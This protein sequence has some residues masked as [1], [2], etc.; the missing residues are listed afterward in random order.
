[1]GADVTEASA[2]LYRRLAVV[3]GAAYRGLASVRLSLERAQ[4]RCARGLV[5]QPRS[6][7][8]F[9]VA[10]PKAGT[11]VL[12]MMLYQLLSDGDPEFRHIDC[13][14]PWFDIHL[15]RDVLPE[16]RTS[17]RVF[18]THL[19]LTELPSGGRY[20]Y[21][22]RDPKDSCVS[23][24]HQFTAE[25]GRRVPLERFVH[26]FLAGDVPWG[27][28]VDHVRSCA[29]FKHPDRVL[30]VQYADLVTN[31]S[32]VVDRVAHFIG[33]KLTQAKRAETLER[34][35]FAYMKTRNVKF[36][37]RWAAGPPDS[38][39]FIRNGRNGG[40]VDELTPAMART[41]DEWAECGLENLAPSVAS[42]SRVRQRA[43][44]EPEHTNAW[45]RAVD[46]RRQ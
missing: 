13:V 38:A 10:Y 5:H 24:Y 9:I 3:F 6:D 33:V 36:D 26:Q 42:M 19:P 43:D 45:R 46:A 7:D 18:K 22:L 8:I 27:S 15:T 44:D 29:R 25:A 35:S 23:Y 37:P 34:C 2:R 14:V 41:I 31:P 21:L 28:W 1:M 17:R 40:W 39:L 4:Y 32:D 11:T 20:V 12:Q 30:T 16:P